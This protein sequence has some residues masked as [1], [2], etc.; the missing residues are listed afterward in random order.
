MKIGVLALQGAFAEHREKIR[1]LNVDVAEVRMPKD[2]EDID[3]LIIPGGETTSIGK[4]LE[5]YKLRNKI[6]ERY[7]QGM[8]IYGTCAG[9]ILLAKKSNTSFFDNNFSLK[10]MDIKVERNAYGRQLDSFSKQIKVSIPKADKFEGIFIRAPKITA[11][12]KN[13]KILGRLEDSV[14]AAQ[15]DNLLVTT[16]H[17]ELTKSTAFHEYFVDMVR[18][19]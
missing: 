8:C 2:L 4:L 17:P 12:S 7:K 1:K 18:K 5:R 14:I 11:V 10:L 13:V 19:K 15:Q 6:I 16:F 9:T 3:G